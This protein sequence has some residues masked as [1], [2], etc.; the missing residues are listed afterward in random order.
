MHN[1]MIF[2]TISGFISPNSPP[3]ELRLAMSDSL[4][5]PNAYTLA[6]PGISFFC[7]APL[8]AETQ[9]TRSGT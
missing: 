5:L 4:S 6:L 1:N 2:F 9:L 3:S 8:T 7:S